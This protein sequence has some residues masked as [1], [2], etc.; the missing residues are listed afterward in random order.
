MSGDEDNFLS[1]FK[2]KIEDKALTSTS[3]IEDYE[4]TIQEKDNIIKQKDEKI[5]DLNK[6]VKE[7]SVM[8]KEAFMAPKST[9]SLSKASPQDAG[10][11]QKKVEKLEAENAKLK[12]AA[13]DYKRL[14]EKNDDLKKEINKLKVKKDFDLSQFLEEGEDP[15][16]AAQVRVLKTRIKSLDK[17][18][19]E[20]EIDDIK[21]E[22]E[23]KRKTFSSLQKENKEL[24][25]KVKSLEA[26]V[27]IFEHSPPPPPPPTQKGPDLTPSFSIPEIPSLSGTKKL[28]GPPA[29]PD[30]PSSPP[31]PPG[32][33][34]PPGTPS[35]PPGPPGPPAPPGTPSSPPGPP[36]PPAPPGTPSSPPGPPGPPAPPGT[37]SSPPGPPAVLAQPTPAM[38]GGA[39]SGSREVQKL[40]K[41]LK[42]LQERY[43]IIA[44]EIDEFK[45]NNDEKSIL[46]LKTHRIYDLEDALKKLRKEVKEN[47]VVKK[48]Q[49]EIDEK[50]EK[51]E[52][53]EESIKKLEDEKENLIKY[54]N[55]LK[56]N[57]ETVYQMVGERDTLLANMREELRKLGFQI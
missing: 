56:Q 14:K 34:A 28:P 50:V 38:F 36:G 33:P 19:Q 18:I 43:A 12:E 57:Y 31:G 30:M 2:K 5:A 55:E 29:P 8:A 10:S 32:P 52:E 51:L 45:L 44:K 22:L 17:K 26:Q 6:K 53:Q 20:Y 25:E 49:E 9:D 46:N 41:E 42:N 15:T 11:L 37:P 21:E 35:S 16:L 4:V 27:D 48:M 1:S 3:R 39:P 24:K 7:L 23:E 54:Y 47:A 13:K 40:K